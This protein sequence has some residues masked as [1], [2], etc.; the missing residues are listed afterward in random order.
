MKVPNAAT[1]NNDWV[2]LDQF[3]GMKINSWHGYQAMYNYF[4]T[5]E[6]LGLLTIIDSY[7]IVQW[8]YLSEGKNTYGPATLK[9]IFIMCNLAALA[10]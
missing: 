10:K 3:L 2:M 7:N 6:T 9:I 1:Q 4:V 8:T 5:R